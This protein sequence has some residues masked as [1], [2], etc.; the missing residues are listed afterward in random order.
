MAIPTDV[1]ANESEINNCYTFSIAD[2]SLTFLTDDCCGVRQVDS[3][4]IDDIQSPEVNTLDDVIITHRGDQIRR[5]DDKANKLIDGAQN[6][7]SMAKELKDK[8]K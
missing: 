7:F 6:F 1:S 5:L 2:C 8:I 3:D 4:V